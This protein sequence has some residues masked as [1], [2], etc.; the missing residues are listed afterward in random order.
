MNFS[1]QKL[2]GASTLSPASLARWREA[3]ILGG[4]HRSHAMVD[5]VCFPFPIGV[6]MKPPRNRGLKLI[7][8]DI[9]GIWIVM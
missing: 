2:E 8:D 4:E 6:P 7:N 5:T 9:M 3:W 1:P